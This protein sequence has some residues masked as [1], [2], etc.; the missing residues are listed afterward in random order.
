MWFH[1][2]QGGGC[3]LECFQI[4]VSKWKSFPAKDFTKTTAH[5][6]KDEGMNLKG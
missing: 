2:D 4:V 1:F 5:K 6:A 3:N